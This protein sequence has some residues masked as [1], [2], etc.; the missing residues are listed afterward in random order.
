MAMTP[1]YTPYQMKPLIDFPQVAPL[2][3]LVSMASPTP[4]MNPGV[5]ML[6]PRSTQYPANFS[7]RGGDVTG[8]FPQLPGT[9]YTPQAL[10][11]VPGDAPESIP[12]VIPMGGMEA[13]TY[14][15][16]GDEDSTSDYRN[17]A[18]YTGGDPP[19]VQP[20][21]G[22]NASRGGNILDRLLSRSFMGQL[23]LALAGLGGPYGRPDAL[24]EVTKRRLQQD[25]EAQALRASLGVMGQ[26][27]Q[28]KTPAEAYQMLMAAAANAQSAKGVELLLK[29]AEPYHKRALAS[30]DALK[31]AQ[32][33]SA[34]PANATRQ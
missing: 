16:S 34:I 13:S 30:E 29:S 14:P 25:E 9:R 11:T 33:V 18:G 15:P 17:F 4:D 8:Q 21:L 32:V 22:A 26:A 2:P 10:E 6:D 23:G 7:P 31:V 27:S 1:L 19:T 20:G 12:G 5:P 24:M 28:A 3:N